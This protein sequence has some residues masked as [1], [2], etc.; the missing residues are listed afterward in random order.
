MTKY[1]V[2]VLGAGPAGIAAAR[3]AASTG[4]RVA[5]VEASHVGGAC[6]HETCLPTEVLLNLMQSHDQAVLLA[7]FGVLQG[8]TGY[9]HNRATAR[10]E[11]LIRAISP[12]VA[13]GLSASGVDIVRGF[14]S[15]LDASSVQ[16]KG[17]EGGS[18]LESRAFVLATGSVWQPPSGPGFP[19]GRVITPDLV[20][21][22]HPLPDRVGILTSENA[23]GLFPLEYASYLS[24]VGVAVDLLSAGPALLPALDPDLEPLVVAGF[25]T[26]GCTVH[27]H[28]TA[29]GFEGDKL[30]VGVA[31]GEGLLDVP[32]L[33]AADTRVAH[34]AGLQ[35]DRLGLGD[36]PL[37]VDE[38]MRSP[39]PGI[40]VA[41]DLTGEPLLSNMAAEEGTCAGFNA[42]GV[43]RRRS[44]AAPP[45][46]LHG[47]V[48]AAWVGLGEHD[49]RARHGEVV[50]G[51]AEMTGSAQATVTGQDGAVVKLVATDLG[52]VVGVH[53]VGEGAAEIVAMAAALMQLEATVEDVAALTPWHPSWAEG[54]VLAA[55]TTA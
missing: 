33:L 21:T 2:V 40:F 52:E 44:Q 27:L 11:A 50:T 46:V 42:A 16:V 13:R 51:I 23:H 1:D 19:Q 35:L 17:A 31:T 6:V 28:T 29:N 54:L 15:F 4:A 22:R 9:D 8:T 38:H 53:A 41:G 47:R 14:A 26:F 3:S 25:E 34:T 10:K 36:G 24:G 37:Q 48:P 39:A 20:Q 18:T 45:F 30:R 12:I 55:R 49:A 7:A 5:I 32:V 43:A